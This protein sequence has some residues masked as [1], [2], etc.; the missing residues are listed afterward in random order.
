MNSKFR[1]YEQKKK[2]S[3]SNESLSLRATQ[4]MKT[5]LG[6][7][8]DLVSNC[9]RGSSQM[10]LSINSNIKDTTI[11]ASHLNNHMTSV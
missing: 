2:E 5:Q 3:R 6:K 4:M 7:E 10:G 11:Q 1:D 9:S 8:G